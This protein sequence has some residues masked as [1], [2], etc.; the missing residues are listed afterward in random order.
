MIKQ[1]HKN[2]LSRIELIP[3]EARLVRQSP[4]EPMTSESYLRFTYLKLARINR[5][6]FITC[7]AFGS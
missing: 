1:S 5:S 2:T 6:V 3:K 4:D 7:D